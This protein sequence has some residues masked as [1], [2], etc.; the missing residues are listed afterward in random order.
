MEDVVRIK[1]CKADFL[2]PVVDTCLVQNCVFVCI[3]SLLHTISPGHG[4]SGGEKICT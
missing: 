3:F 2:H 1:Y 4:L